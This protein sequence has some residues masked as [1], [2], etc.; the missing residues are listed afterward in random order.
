MVNNGV[1]KPYMKS[2]NW[3]TYWSLH[4]NVYPFTH[5]QLPVA[6]FLALSC[7]NLAEVDFG[8]TPCSTCTLDSADNQRTGR[9]Q[10][11]VNALSFVGK[12]SRFPV[13]R[14]SPC[15]MWELG[16][17]PEM[18]AYN[19]T[20]TV[21]RLRCFGEAS[22]IECMEYSIKNF[23]NFSKNVPNFYRVATFQSR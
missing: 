22:F 5:L 6:L 10:R 8:C 11:S 20:C 23:L 1:I 15:C 14:L 3:L 7:C 17:P 12:E 4:E 13:P 9:S 19:K 21:C 16:L 18:H 2:Q